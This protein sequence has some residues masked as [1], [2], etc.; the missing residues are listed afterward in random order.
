MFLKRKYIRVLIQTNPGRW[1]FFSDCKNWFCIS[2]DSLMVWWINLQ[3]EGAVSKPVRV[4]LLQILVYHISFTLLYWS[5]LKSW[6]VWSTERE[7]ERVEGRE[8]HLICPHCQNDFQ[9]PCIWLSVAFWVLQTH[10]LIDFC[11]FL[12]EKSSQ[13]CP[14]LLYY[15]LDFSLYQPPFLSLS[16]SSFYIHHGC[17]CELLLLPPCWP[18]VLEAYGAHFILLLLPADERVI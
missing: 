7:R 13:I 18:A 12:S 5:V 4:R 6:I 10:L 3:L 9:P 15:L 1:I 11:A 17:L 2:F 14:R 16:L 8:T